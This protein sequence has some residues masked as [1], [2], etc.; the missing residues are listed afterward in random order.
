MTKITLSYDKQNELA[1]AIGQLDMHEVAAP[2]K[3][4]RAPYKL[5]SERRALVKNMKA[6]QESISTWQEI[7]KQIFK[8]NF[9]DVPDGVGVHQKDRPIAYAKYMA[10]ITASGQQEEEIELIPF[11]AKAMYDDNE[12][13]AAVLALLEKYEL[14]EDV[15]KPAKL[16]EVK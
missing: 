9:P 3:A 15:S 14:I 16:R 6:L 11:S 10:E 8:E 5:G 7:T 12:F 2:D 1:A 4:I 13:P